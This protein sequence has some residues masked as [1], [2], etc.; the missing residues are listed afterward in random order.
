MIDEEEPKHIIMADDSTWIQ[1]QEWYPEHNIGDSI[2]GKRDIYVKPSEIAAVISHRTGALVV[3][4]GGKSV[5]VVTSVSDTVKLIQKATVAAAIDFEQI[6]YEESL[7]K[8]D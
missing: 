7:E 8:H 4:R 6:S 2:Q 1:L 5:D 3:L